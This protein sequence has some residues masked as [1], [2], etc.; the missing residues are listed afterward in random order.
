MAL[1]GA[2]QM[3]LG[4]ATQVARRTSAGEAQE[5]HQE[6][7]SGETEDRRLEV[8]VTKGDSPLKE[9]ESLKPSAFH[10]ASV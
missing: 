4:A 3:F 5:G 2:G 10:L 6:E 1:K 7:G 9:R 8:S